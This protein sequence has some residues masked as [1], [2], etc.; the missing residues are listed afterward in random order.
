MAV[1]W[2]DCIEN[3][4]L[5]QQVYMLTTAW[6]QFCENMTVVRMFPWDHQRSPPL[7]IETSILHLVSVLA[8]SF[9][10]LNTYEHFMRG[11]A[12]PLMK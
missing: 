11:K 1:L 3:L 12:I 9:T 2:D 8:L 7:P 4:K 10:P 5:Q 6:K